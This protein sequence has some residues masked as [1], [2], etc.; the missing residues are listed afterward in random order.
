MRP[1]TPRRPCQRGGAFGKL[2]FLSAAK[3]VRQNPIM[4]SEAVT[5]A[6]AGT[7]QLGDLTVNRIGFGAMRL[8]GGAAFGLGTPSARARAARSARR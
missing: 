5:A 3:T 7:W 6:A 1:R 8:T 2:L 4:T